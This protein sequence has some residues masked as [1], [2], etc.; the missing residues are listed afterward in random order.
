ML[1]ESNIYLHDM[2]RV[3]ID[4]EMAIIN[5]RFENAYHLLKK[6]KIGNLDEFFSKMKGQVTDKLFEI[7]GE[8][9]DR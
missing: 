5:G 3:L 6:L 1:K 9:H 8:S 4:I 7:Y 2:I